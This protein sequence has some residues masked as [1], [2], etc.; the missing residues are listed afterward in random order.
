MCYLVTDL[1]FSSLT[2]FSPSTAPAVSTSECSTM[3]SQ[4]TF[5][6]EVPSCCTLYNHCDYYYLTVLVIY[7]CLKILKND[8]ALMTMYSYNLHPAQP[9]EDWPPLIAPQFPLYDSF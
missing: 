4:L 3:K 5:T 6:P 7:E 1:L 2:P 8:L 9:E